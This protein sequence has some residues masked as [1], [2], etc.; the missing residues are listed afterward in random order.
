MVRL[1]RFRDYSFNCL[2]CEGGALSRTAAC[3][4]A[5][6]QCRGTYRTSQAK[7]FHPKETIPA[8]SNLDP[9]SGGMRTPMQPADDAWQL[10]LRIPAALAPLTLAYTVR[11]PGNGKGASS[12]ADHIVAPKMGGNFCVPVGMRPGSPAPFGEALPFLQRSSPHAAWRQGH[13]LA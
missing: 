6:H 13:D 1:S 12:A 10:Q 5:M 9:R 4:K 8:G 3:L 7:W 2:E 11:V